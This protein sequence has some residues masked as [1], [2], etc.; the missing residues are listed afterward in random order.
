MNIQD[1]KKVIID[2]ANKSI[3]SSSNKIWT[4]RLNKEFISFA[5]KNNL[6]VYCKTKG[7]DWRE[8]LYDL[9]ICEQNNSSP[10]NITSTKLVMESE[11]IPKNDEII[12]DFQKLLLCNSDYKILVFYK[13][14]EIIPELIKHIKSYSNTNGTFLLACYTEDKGYIFETIT[15]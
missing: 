10:Y 8:W 2:A 6:K 1:I 5:H 9:T 11:W 4:K 7:A 12:E 14:S 13:K 3:H 15:I